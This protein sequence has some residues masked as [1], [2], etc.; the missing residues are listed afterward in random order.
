MVDGLKPVAT[1]AI[2]ARMAVRGTSP[3]SRTGAISQAAAAGK[4]PNPAADLAAWGPIVDHAR[5]EGLKDA[6][7]NGS[8][9]AEPGAIAKAMIAA[10][11]PPGP[12]A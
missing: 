5:I 1:S 7:A 12:K 4:V 8:Y 10:D 2:D 6:I 3:V 9:K 11:L